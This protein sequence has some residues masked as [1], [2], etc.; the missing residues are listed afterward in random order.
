MAR[1]DL[2]LSIE[3]RVI[4]VFADQYLGKQRGVANPP[5]IGRSGAGA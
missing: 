1:D 4:A 3:R 5:A 2:Q